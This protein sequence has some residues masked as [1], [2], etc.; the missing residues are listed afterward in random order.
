M[1]AKWMELRYAARDNGV[2]NESCEPP[3]PTI[4]AGIRLR[5][6]V[7]RYCGLMPPATVTASTK[8]LQRQALEREREAIR[9]GLT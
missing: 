6:F 3:P 4:F 8:E 7:W 1:A 5:V 9:A 2:R